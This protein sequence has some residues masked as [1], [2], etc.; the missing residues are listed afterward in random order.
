MN[1]PSTLRAFVLAL[2][3]GSCASISGCK[4]KETPA[5]RG[6]GQ[7]QSPYDPKHPVREGAATLQEKY[8]G[9]CHQTPAPALLPRRA[10]STVLNLMGLYLGRDDTGL[11]KQLDNA[12][13]TGPVNRS[14]LPAQSLIGKD[15][16]RK[17]VDYYLQ[18]SPAGPLRQQD[19]PSR[20]EGLKLFRSWPPAYNP[21]DAAISLVAIDE[22]NKVIHIGDSR[23][24]KLSS[25]RPDGKVLRAGL[26]SGFPVGIR[27]RNDGFFLTLAGSLSPSN[28][29]HG[30]VLFYRRQGQRFERVTLLQRLYRTTHTSFADVNQDG[31]EDI[32]VCGAGFHVGSFSWFEKTTGGYTEHVLMDRAGAVHAHVRDWNGDGRPDLMVLMA[33]GREG[34]Y[35]FKSKSDGSLE[36]YAV[37]EKHP[38]FG[39]THFAVGDIDG[40]GKVDV[41]TANGDNGNLSESPL[42]GYHGIRVLEH[43]GMT[44]FREAY[45]YPMYG[46][47]RVVTAD[48]DGDGDIDIA[49]IAFFPDFSDS[50]PETFVYLENLGKYRFQPH[51]L[52]A[53]YR[54]R[55][56]SLDAG[57]MDGDGDVDIVLGAAYIEGVGAPNYST[58][59]RSALYDEKKAVLILENTTASAGP[60]VLGP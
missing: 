6:A 26:V 59:E 50:K 48:F 52:A 10:W 37:V 49:A 38:A 56:F 14:L 53:T 35:I 20:R 55:W 3:V 21:P 43:Q 29:K 4:S 22:K 60:P 12:S 23:H 13:G 16:W 18:N 40:D 46:A 41:V 54:G 19:K 44:K 34:L 8:C 57:D 58:W 15:D 39:Y 36:R 7:R 1:R 45:F 24:Q 33:G 27:V 30:S 2:A 5:K 28:E 31:Q 51:T 42:R 17:L 25:L 32:V 47:S 11:L 9:G